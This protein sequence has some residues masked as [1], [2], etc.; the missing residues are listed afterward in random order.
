MTERP[1]RALTE[2]LIMVE[3]F[4]E[5]YFV[6]DNEAFVVQQLRDRSLELLLEQVFDLL[7]QSTSQVS[8]RVDHHFLKITSVNSQCSNFIQKNH[9]QMKCRSH[10]CYSR[11]LHVVDVPS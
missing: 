3:H 1:S 2:I 8:H 9:P 10:C 5:G 7:N 6:A 11:S 4:P